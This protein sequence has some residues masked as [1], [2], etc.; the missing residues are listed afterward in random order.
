MEKSTKEAKKLGNEIKN[1]GSKISKVGSS[2]TTKFTLPIAAAGT[3]SFKLASDLNESVNKVDVSFGK[4]AKNIKNWS[5]TTL[6]SYGIAQGTALDMS[7]TYGDM[8]TSMGLTTKQA[9]KMSKTLVGRAGDLSSF[10]NISI[11]IANTA[12]NGIFS[13]ETESLKKLGVVMTDTNLQA[14]AV[15]KGLLKSTVSAAKMKEMNLKVTLAQQTLNEKTKKF[16]A[17]S[18]E[19]KKAQISLNSA[20]GN[21]AKTAKGSFSSLSQAEKVQLRYKYVLDMTKNSQGDFAKTLGTS[22]ANQKRALVEGMKQAGASIGTKLLPQGLKLLKWINSLVGKFSNLSDK[23]QN[24][25]I[26]FA[27]I[28]AAVGPCVFILGKLT[29]GVGI[30]INVFKMARMATMM[31]GA[32]GLLMLIPP[33][34]IVV[35]VIVAIAVAAFLIIKNW[36]KVKAF[37]GGLGKFLKNTFKRA[38]GDVN[39]F[40]KL[41]TKAKT[42]ISNAIKNLKPAINNIIKY[43]KPI[44]RFL[45]NV[46]VAGF[47]VQFKIVSGYVS[48]VVKG[49]SGYINGL[50]DV[51]DGITTFIGGVFTGNWKKAWLGVKK[52]FGGIAESLV[53]VIKTPIN[54]I[55]GIVNGAVDG[56]NSLGFKIPD[57]VPLLGGKKFSINIPKI[58]MLATGTPNWKGGL[59][60]TQ[61]RGG[62]IM[63]LPRG[64]RVYPHDK[65]VRMARKEGA[66]GKGNVTVI[67]KKL[68][69][70]IEVRS[71]KDIDEI[72]RKLADELEKRAN[73]Q[74][75]VVPA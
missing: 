14:Y 21:Q 31:F 68:A 54:A 71:N 25:I 30:I 67:V 7:A 5:K 57:W 74:G 58:P 64:T 16:G 70:K 1:A 53:A 8:A 72:V 17:N 40:G 47:K 33:A 11:D 20:L 10:K 32:K 66:K 37:F 27:G 35:A 22:A 56:I 3:A 45:K 60:V 2:L 24:M 41:F 18:I 62:E 34:W 43:M 9:A 29:T 13:G 55:I 69:E 6:T 38:G 73:N 46:F 75:E 15:S 51:F 50:L 12:L 59:A 52:I 19:T 49:I 28:A 36:K 63:D 42:V 48:G 39:I 26:K 23:Q 44:V 61:E 65:S 4:N